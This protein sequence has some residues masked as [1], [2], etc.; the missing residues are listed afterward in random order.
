LNIVVCVKPV[1]D[2]E[3]YNQLNID[4]ATKRLVRAG[5]PTVINPSDRNALEE[6]LRIRDSIGGK[7][8]VMS[9]APLFSQDKVKECLAMGAD[10]AYIIS[11]QMYG[12]S[13]TLATSYIIAMAIKKIVMDV[14]LILAGNESADG[15][16]AHVPSQLAEWLELPHI[17]N[18]TYLEVVGELLNV[19]KKID[20]GNIDYQIKLP[21]LVAV[22]RG[23][24][25]PR[26]ISALGII[27]AK[28]KKLEIVTQSELNLD[29]SYIGLP[30][31]PTQPGE[32]FVPDINRKT[33]KMD[34]EIEDVAKAVLKIIKKEG[35][36]L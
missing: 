29:S 21:A 33:I 34:G 8:T 10:E 1:P 30:G 26:L 12:G 35:I 2:P 11:D 5:I 24:N 13:D 14:D 9:M 16:T 18:A 4:P 27:K 7:V 25:K 31:S 17:S 23:S 15:A 3:K 28:S 32:L 22:A 19:Q 36:T 6:G 20:N